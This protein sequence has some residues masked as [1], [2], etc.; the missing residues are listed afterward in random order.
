MIIR[1]EFGYSC[2][3]IVRN[4]SSERCKF[5]IHA[6]TYKLELLLESN[7]LDN[8]Q[9]VYDFGLLKG[10][11][12]EAVN[13]FNNSVLV[14]NK[15][16]HLCD[17]AKEYAN[18]YIFLPFSSSAEM[19]SVYFFRLFDEILK[20]TQINNGEGKVK[21][22]SVKVHETVTGYAEAFKKDKNILNENIFSKMEL[23]DSVKPEWWDKFVNAIKIKDNKSLFVNPKI[24]LQIK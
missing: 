20:R 8:G 9:M 7:D 10:T 21:V 1:K 16:K 5:S 22:H 6:H 23:S 17:I 2:S 12:K 18:R 19:Q 13:M 11:I 4:C 24:K 15:D 3:H 14:W